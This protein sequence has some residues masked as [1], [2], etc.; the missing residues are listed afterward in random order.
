MYAMKA[1][2]EGYAQ[3]GSV[4]WLGVRAARRS[5]MR[6]LE[7]VLIAPEGLKGDHA[8]AGKRAVTLIQAEHLPVIGAMLGREPVSPLDLRRNIVVSGINLVGL[9]GRPFRLGR[10]VLEITTVCAPCS[11]MEE[12]FGAG[13]YSAVRG[14]G[15]WCATV[16]QE[17]EV[18]LGDP[19][20]PVQ[21]D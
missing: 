7:H 11:R 10:A 12:T 13:G 6:A 19:V 14:H 1:L 9:K 20:V 5:E 16:L 2:I 15:G 8:R 21:S 18:C 4:D 17:G 3:A